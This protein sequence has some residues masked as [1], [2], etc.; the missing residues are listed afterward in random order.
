MNDPIIGET[1]TLDD[2]TLLIIGFLLLKK[3]H[4]WSG[5]AEE[6]ANGIANLCSQ[7]GIKFIPNARMVGKALNRDWD[8]IGALFHLGNRRISSGYTFYTIDGIRIDEE[9]VKDFCNTIF[10]EI[11][12]RFI[13]PPKI[14]IKA[15]TFW[16]TK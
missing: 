14:S 16:I 9:K 10:S 11:R 15:I 1:K 7:M 8:M 4:A 5:H 6:L 12:S 3:D 2:V 13:D